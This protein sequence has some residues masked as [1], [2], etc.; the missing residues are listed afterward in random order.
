MY[1]FKVFILCLLLKKKNISL[2]T[3]LFLFKFFEKIKMKSF[4]ETKLC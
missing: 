2:Y 4:L 3:K 1:W